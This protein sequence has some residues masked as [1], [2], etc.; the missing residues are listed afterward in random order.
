[1]VELSRKS[2]EA[3]VYWVNGARPFGFDT[4]T[5][6]FCQGTKGASKSTW[7]EFLG[8]KNLMAGNCLLDAHCSNDNESLARLD[9]PL[10]EGKKVLLLRG[11]NTSVTSSW[12]D[13]DVNKLTFS[14]FDHYDVILS[15]PA[16]YYPR[17]QAV[18][19]SINT[20]VD[21]LYY[22]ESYN[23][24]VYMLVREAAS[25]FY[26]R[27]KLEWAQLEAKGR[28]IYMLREMR[29]SGVSLGLDT[30][31][32]KSIDADIRNLIDFLF[33]MAQGAP[34]LPDDLHYLYSWWDPEKLQRLPKG[35]FVVRT[36]EGDTGWGHFSYLPWHKVEKENMREAFGIKVEHSDPPK[37]P[38]GK[39]GAVTDSEHAFMVRRYKELNPRT[40]RHYSMADVAIESKHSPTT[41]QNQLANHD[42]AIQMNGFCP[43]CKR[44]LEEP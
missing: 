28:M 32:D 3:K 29:H 4:A 17:P 18:Y 24:L 5:V 26:S 34:G 43:R 8:S 27:L 21:L 22:R 35:E 9:D 6:S 42:A 39:E 12:D 44:A 13:K 2:P 14:D 40:Q 16:F 38:N 7:L 19:D 33:L 25:L 15:P 37:Q 20:L 10:I 1:M 36:K 41:V 30:L 23:R 31:K 11:P